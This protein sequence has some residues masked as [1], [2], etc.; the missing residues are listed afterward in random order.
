MTCAV[1]VLSFSMSK[2][3]TETEIRNTG[4]KCVQD[5]FTSSSTVTYKKIRD[6]VDLRGYIHSPWY[7]L[8]SDEE[9]REIRSAIAVGEGL[10]SD[11]DRLLFGCWCMRQVWDLIP[12]RVKDMVRN[13]E[14]YGYTYG[15]DD[16]SFRE[17]AIEAIGDRAW[18]LAA[19][20]YSSDDNSEARLEKRR[21]VQNAEFDQLKKLVEMVP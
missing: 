5:A 13:A 4:A 15:E 2:R 17:Q 18:D 20:K 12:R 21:A 1:Q 6:N 3:Y 9:R 10:L 11:K 7:V 8:V 14:R 19:E 16:L